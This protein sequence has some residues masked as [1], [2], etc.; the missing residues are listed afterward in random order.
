LAA[1]DRSHLIAK[2]TLLLYFRTLI[3]IVVTFYTI[4]VLLSVLGAEDFGVFGIL[5]GVIILISFFNKSMTTSTQRFI[6]YEIGLGEKGNV[7]E[8]F[9][10][11]LTCHL[12]VAI[13]L[14]IIAETAGL[15]FVINVLNIPEER[16]SAALWIYQLYLA[17]MVFFIIA[18][19]FNALILAHEKMNIFTY[20][21][22]VDVLLKLAVVFVIQYFAGDKLILYVLLLSVVSLLSNGY[23]VYYC[24]TK[25]KELNFRLS[26]NK[27][28]LI[29]LFTFSG[30][31]T[32]GASAD[33]LSEQG[34]NILIN[35]FFGPVYNAT[36]LLAGKIQEGV[37]MLISNLMTAVKPQIVKSYS[38]NDTSFLYKLVFSSSKF[39][40]FLLYF[41]TLPFFFQ[42]DFFLGLWLTEVPEYLRIF[43]QLIIVDLLVQA[44]FV[45]MGIL[46]Q[47][48]AKIKKYQIIVSLNFLSVF[49]FTALFYK[50]GFP[51][52]AAFIITIIM[53]VLA[54]FARLYE[55]KKTLNFPVRKFLSDVTLRLVCTTLL[56]VVLPI[57][58]YIL[59]DSSIYWVCVSIVVCFISTGTVIWLVG[60]NKFEKDFIVK[61]IKERFQ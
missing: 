10:T 24:R 6:N 22:I 5:S 43:V 37:Y 54:F 40:F 8:I 48:S 36:K 31:M 4:R 14:V 61:K 60:L 32:A 58:I 2:N 15:W 27:S 55:I 20:V 51:V 7:K 21:S 46:S 41:I 17:Y 18:S 35:I 42:A 12:I 39:S 56:S 57:I 44:S 59:A 38:Q 16:M 33:T 19:P 11:T 28:R 34:V 50:I 23:Y 53:S 25:Y 49:C 30:W 1:I 26:W 3:T 45:S 29:K 9:A 52:Y 13:L 47:A